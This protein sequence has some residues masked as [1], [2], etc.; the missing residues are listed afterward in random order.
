MTAAVI[1]EQANHLPRA[2]W[3][4]QEYP[5][6]LFN[7]RLWVEAQEVGSESDPALS[8]HGCRLGDGV[9]STWPSAPAE[10]SIR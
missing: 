3:M 2:I 5:V 7:R 4:R 10:R 6:D 1:A 8:P 9:A